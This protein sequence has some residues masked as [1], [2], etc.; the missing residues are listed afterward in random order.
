MT[1]S[2][3]QLVIGSFFMV[4]EGGPPPVIRLNEFYLGQ[5]KA[6][7]FGVSAGT[8][9]DLT[10]HVH[11]R[12]LLLGNTIFGRILY[13]HGEQLDPP[14]DECLYA[15]LFTFNTPH[16]VTGQMEFSGDN[17]WH[18]LSVPD[19][20]RVVITLGVPA[21][22]NYE[23]EVWD[24]SCSTRLDYSHTSGSIETVHVTSSGATNY[25]IHVFGAGSD[26]YGAAYQEISSFIL[27]NDP[28]DDYCSEANTFTFNVGHSVTGNLEFSGD[29]D[30][31]RIWIPENVGTGKILVTLKVPA[32]KNYDLELWSDDCSS[33]LTS[34]QR[35]ASQNEYVAYW[36]VPGQ[37]YRTHIWGAG[38]NDFA[39][40]YVESSALHFPPTK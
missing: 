10:L 13:K 37:Y 28:N 17:D 16:N 3:N 9:Y 35:P 33:K 12:D 14:D 8:N 5:K 6:G 36:V 32:S 24:D 18:R 39:L 27:D 1:P 29:H 19:A 30:W 2:Q 21:N 34:S 7:E 15:D 38:P 22:K 23:L 31:H 11:N 40:P 4:G 26:D 25:R 20:G